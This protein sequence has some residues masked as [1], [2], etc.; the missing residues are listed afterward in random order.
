MLV[1]L[2]TTEYV[3]AFAFLCTYYASTLITKRDLADVAS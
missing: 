3:S 2:V 1:T